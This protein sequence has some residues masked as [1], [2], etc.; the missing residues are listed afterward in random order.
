[1]KQA[2]LIFMLA[3]FAVFSAAC[4][5]DGNGEEDAD[6]APD[7]EQ[8]TDVETEDDSEVP[9]DVPVDEDGVEEEDGA[10]VQEDD[11]AP[12]APD[13]ADGD[14]PLDVPVDEIED[15]ADI[16]DIPEEEIVE[17]DATALCDDLTT[18]LCT[19]ISGCCTADEQTQ[20]ASFVSCS[21]IRAGTFW[22]DCYAGYG[23]YIVDG[24]A[25]IYDAAVPGCLAVFY[26]LASSCPSFNAAPF[27]KPWYMNLGCSEIVRG[28][29]SPS[30]ECESSEQCA[31]Q[32][33]CDFSASPAV[34][35]A[36]G[37]IGGACGL[38]DACRRGYVCVGGLCAEPS[39][40]GGDCDEHGDCNLGLYCDS[41]G[42]CRIMLASGQSCSESD[43]FCEGDCVTSSCQDTCNGL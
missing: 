20:V 41:G 26:D 15:T 32:Y 37:A 2:L 28:T 33:Y 34:C 21:A 40:D 24:T 39:N 9:P 22:N 27:H 30:Q 11:A 10:D 13:L 8:D 43:D 4:D 3:G 5:G 1:M 36:R 31:G 25:T 7:M 17:N 23:P 35:T 12:D 14:D 29:Y 18:A 16:E 38:N 6:A 19:Y 42:A